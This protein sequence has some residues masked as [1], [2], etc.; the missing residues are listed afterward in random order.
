MNLVTDPSEL[1]TLFGQSPAVHIY[2]LGDLDEPFWS[3]SRWFRR[4]DAVVGLVDLGSPEP[5][6]ILVYAV[7]DIA[8]SATIRLLIDLA[9]EIPDG[10]L[11]VAPR[12]AAMWTSESRSVEAYGPHFKFSLPDDAR[13]SASPKVVQLHEGDLAE[14]T[15]LYNTDP[16]SAFFLPNMLSTGVWAGVRERG[17]LLAA[18]GTHLRSPTYKVAA[19]GGVFTR[20]DVRGKGFGTQLTSWLADNLL[21]DGYL[22]GLNVRAENLIARRLYTNLGF[23]QI[24]EYEEFVFLGEEP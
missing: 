1:A 5:F 24:H 18:G 7:S 19:L 22:V 11:A 15:A 8:P 17:V 14:L 20:P 13:L 16:G 4:G 21:K 12:G 10:S 3:R 2:G 23:I 9:E 6:N